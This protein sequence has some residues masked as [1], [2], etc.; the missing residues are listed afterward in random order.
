MPE[1]ELPPVSPPHGRDK[2]AGGLLKICRPPAL[3]ARK[4]WWSAQKLQTSSTIGPKTLVV[5][6]KI[7]DLRHRSRNIRPPAATDR[8]L[9]RAL[10]LKALLA[11][12][13]CAVDRV[14]LRGHRESLVYDMSEENRLGR[15][16]GLPDLRI[17]KRQNFLITFAR[18]SYRGEPGGIFSEAPDT[19]LPQK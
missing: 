12:D 15:L 8:A 14:E 16:T 4:R 10:A 18:F 11:P 2:N 1:L 19:F 3:K 5:C 7:A 13:C 17:R 6:L 9:R